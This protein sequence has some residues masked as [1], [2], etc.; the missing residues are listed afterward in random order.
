M[1]ASTTPA[2]EAANIVQCP[3]SAESLTP[4]RP[5]QVEDAIAEA[6]QAIIARRSQARPTAAPLSIT[7]P[8]SAVIIAPANEALLE[9]DLPTIAQVEAEIDAI[10]TAS[11]NGITIDGSTPSGVAAATPFEYKLCRAV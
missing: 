6:S 9:S 10:N 8:V 4:E 5:Q 11:R 2:A 3:V 1:M 7:I